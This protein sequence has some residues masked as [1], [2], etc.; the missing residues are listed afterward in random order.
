MTQ[1]IVPLFD[2]V[3]EGQVRE[4]GGP[5][6]LHGRQIPLQVATEDLVMSFLLY[7]PEEYGPQPLMLFF[8]GDMAR[9]VQRSPQP[10]ICDFAT[11]YGPA[12]FAVD[13]KKQWHA[14]RKFVAVTPCCSDKVF[15][16]RY[17]NI[18]DSK[19]YVPSIERCLRTLIGLVYKLG[20][21][22]QDWGA[23]FAGQSMG[24]YMALEL[25]RAMPEQT[26]A[27]V[28]LAPCFDACRLNHLAERLMNV[29]VWV[30]I[31]RNDS[32]CS[33]EECASL[34]LKMRDH[35]AKFVRL[36]SL[37]IKGHSEVGKQLDKEHIYK[38]ML[39]N[40]KGWS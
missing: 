29:P 35:N 16:L 11:D 10:G 5:E 8:H 4:A 27:V 12:L 9:G 13:Q 2:A 15:W 14:C 17:P 26:A 22:K 32:L 6:A 33:F 24:A 37:G 28:A 34:A 3:G 7:V 31:G 36:T 40:I 30:L 25:A 1:R 39:S 23:C 19:T 20:L 38:W 21:S 18:H